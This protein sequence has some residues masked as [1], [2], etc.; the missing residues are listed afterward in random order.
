MKNIRNCSVCNSTV[1]LG[2]FD[3]KVKMCIPCIQTTTGRLSVEQAMQKVRHNNPFLNRA[4]RTKP[5]VITIDNTTTTTTT[6]TTII[7]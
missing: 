3:D 2:L 7:A 6:T 4:N 1:P 5:L